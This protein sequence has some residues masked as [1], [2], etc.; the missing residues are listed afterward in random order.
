MIGRLVKVEK[1]GRIIKLWVRFS[2]KVKEVVEVIDFYPYFYVFD[3]KGEY[4]AIYGGNVKKVIANDPSEVPK[5]R[6]KYTHFE[7]D[8]PYTRRF[9]IDLDLYECVDVPNEKKVMTKQVKPAT[10]DIP[11]R[12]WFLDI[13]V[14]S[15]VLPEPS[16]PEHPICVMTVYDSYTGKYLTLTTLQLGKT[17]GRD[18]WVVE[19]VS[20]EDELAFIFINM[21][22]KTQPDL[23]VGWNVRFDVD[24]LTARFKK[25]GYEFRF[26]GA[27]VFDMLEGFKRLYKRRSYKLK[28]IALEDGLISEYK[29][30]SAGMSPEEMVE[31]NYR[32]VWIMVEL[33]K[34]YGVVDF[35]LQLKSIA[36]VNELEDTLYNSILV[37]TAILR[38][39]KKLGI[40]LPSKPEDVEESD[41]AEYEGAI[42]LEPPKG[43]FDNV[44][45]FDMARY[46]PNI[47]L[48]F[49]I[50]P[51]SYTVA[52]DIKYP[53]TNVAFR[54]DKVGLVPMLVKRLLSL[55]DE[56]EK[57]GAPK[58]KIDAV[59]FIVNSVY[60][61]FGH[62]R[63]RLYNLRLA[64]TVTAI[65]REGILY[66]KKLAEE[67]G[68]KVLY[69]DTDSLHIQIPFNKAEEVVKYLNEDIEKYFREKY[70]VKECTIGLKFEKYFS[71]MMYFGVKKRYAGIMTWEKG[72]E[73][74][75]LVTVG[76]ETV[77]TD[78]SKFSQE[79]QENLLKLVLSG[80][81]K[82]EVMEFINKSIEDMKKAPLIDIA[83]VK[84]LSK[85]LDEYKA[86]VPH[87]RGVLYSN[88]YLG[89]KFG[90]GS[91]VYILW[92]KSVKGLPPTD[93]IA[94][95]EDTKLP[96][97]VVDWR[98]MEDVNIWQK[99]EPILNVIGLVDKSLK[100]W[101]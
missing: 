66:T 36:G 8:I 46:Y 7:A 80:A 48:S 90:K 34:K 86:N 22:N 6:S 69:G 50:S 38:L 84:G 82:K 16:N 1:E 99:A 11:L 31:Y 42:V 75:E 96:E 85:S 56:L 100:V 57:S 21:Y 74:N 76:L 89:T 79:F 28:S 44:A 72:K 45:V 67:L 53:P 12:I 81:S 71:K 62:R 70:G 39:A 78:Q 27:Q 43:I 93:V 91:R 19:Q 25:L 4:K 83:I 41:E 37:D 64:S 14:M 52:G 49:N 17:L 97:L 3:P 9:M 92:V 2:K 26:D 47:I 32:D 73:V 54:S 24:Y 60:G 58:N 13:E 51:D 59:K 63:F 101:F 88:K 94:F 40:V 15:D 55:R 10:C 23:I 68:Y 61:V 95:D 87:V 20:S 33:E 65:G 18:D 98:K 30:F 77:R 35:H 5:L 29:T